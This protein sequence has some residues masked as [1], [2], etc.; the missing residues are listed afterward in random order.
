MFFGVNISAFFNWDFFG[1][2]GHHGSVD[3]SAPSIQQP[4]V[5][6]PLSPSTLLTYKFKFIIPLYLNIS[7]YIE[8]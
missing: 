8:N 6:I 5:Q 1:V 2:G 3:S 7:F 4:W